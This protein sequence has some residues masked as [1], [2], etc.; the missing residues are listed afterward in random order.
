M[1]MNLTNVNDQKK[2]IDY[3]ALKYC[4]I[5]KKKF[6]VIN[7]QCYIWYTGKYWSLFHFR[8]FRPRR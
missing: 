3:E 6:P 1:D 2:N 4:E 5:S 8:P 7:F